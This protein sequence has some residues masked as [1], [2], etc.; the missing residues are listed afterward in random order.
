[1]TVAEFINKVGFK[2]D[3]SSVTKVNNTISDIKSRA[4]KMLSAI[5]VGI[6]LTAINALVEEF[7][8]ANQQIQSAVG[9]LKN[10]TNV[11]DLV[12]E[13]A[14]EAR[15]AYFTDFVLQLTLLFIILSWAEDSSSSHEIDSVEYR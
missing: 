2:V 12:L 3:Q 8:A 15:L 5:G 11:Q 14:N 1:M 13:K 4:A 10:M 6:S 7:G 9:G